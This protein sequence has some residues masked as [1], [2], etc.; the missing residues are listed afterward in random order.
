MCALI[1]LASSE[2]AFADDDMRCPNGLVRVGDLQEDALRKCG[3]P[4][5]VRPGWIRT[6]RGWRF[7]ANYWTYDRG[8]YEFVRVLTIA[9]NYVR[10]IDSGGYGN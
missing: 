2:P 7:V 1:A 8:P 5:S 3:A 4:T 9:D 10:A 6:R